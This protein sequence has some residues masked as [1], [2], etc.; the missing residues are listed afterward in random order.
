MQRICKSTKKI[1]R[2]SEINYYSKLFDTRINNTK[3]IW[4]NINTIFNKSSRNS[5]NIDSILVNG[6][7]LSNP[8]D[9]SNNFNDYFCNVGEVLSN[10]LNGTGA[11]SYTNYLG[12]SITNSFY[13][14][15]VTIGELQQAVSSL[16]TSN[17][18]ACDFI[19]ST[20]LKNC[21]DH[22]ATP[23]LYLCNM[24]FE[25]GQ[26]PDKLKVSKIVPFIK[27][28]IKIPCQII[29]QSHLQAHSLNYLKNLC[30]KDW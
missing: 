9:I 26:F 19:S 3:H 25:Q 1:I 2:T 5:N 7:N 6:M 18:T 23:L 17:S 30:T 8:S 21:F 4:K 10:K 15:S 13:C 28:L 27:N 24:S 14:S 16:K 22:L 12:P 29:G 20:L 11:A